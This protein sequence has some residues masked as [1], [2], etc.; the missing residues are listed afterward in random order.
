M[1]RIRREL[2]EDTF[3]PDEISEFMAEA[4]ERAKAAR[5]EEQRAQR[6]RNLLIGLPIV[7]LGVGFTI[8]AWGQG[9]I[10][11]LPVLLTGYGILECVGARNALWK[12]FL[13]APT[14]HT[15][16]FGRRRRRR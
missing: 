16:D 6:R 13:G 14:D 15:S 9:V 1:S 12:F 10:P 11:F 5:E 2:A 7:A 8:W 3:T 4:V